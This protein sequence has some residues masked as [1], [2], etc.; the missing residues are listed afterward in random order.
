[1]EYHVTFFNG[2][3]SR[4]NKS[5]LIIRNSNWLIEY[6]DPKGE[7]IHCFWLPAF[8][9]PVEVTGRIVSLSYGSFPPA[10]LECDDR[11]LLNELDHT[12]GKLSVAGKM[13]R[14]I[15]EKGSRAMVG[16]TAGLIGLV[17]LIYFIFLPFIAE[18]IAG[19][20]PV[21]YEQKLGYYIS[22]Q[23]LDGY[24]INEE[25]SEKLNKFSQE[26]NFDLD[27]DPNIVAVESE[28]VNA[29]ALPGG[30]IVVFTGLLKN[31]ENEAQLAALLCHEV[32]H[33]KYRHSLKAM[34]RNLAGY[35][36]ISW[37]FTDIN[38]VTA[39]IV[40]NAH[41]LY[42]LNYSREL[43]HEADTK[44]LEMLEENNISQ[45]GMVDLFIILKKEEAIDMTSINFLSTHPLTVERI[46]YSTA[47]AEKQKSI[48]K[49][50]N[51]EQIWID[52]ENI[53]EE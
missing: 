42:S 7:L 32:A 24:Y 1:M 49:N 8:I 35:L 52:I 28:Q 11:K 51:L 26:I 37:L 38:A 25:L 30:T 2:L 23:F 17:A 15:E 6:T 53:L 21:S 44:A 39:I 50:E 12:K 13:F 36:F 45:Q 33:V 41:S 46:N 5:K 40:E 43:E 9:K 20:M 22:N 48:E 16:L 27:F 4:A 18:I 19:T 14:F 47:S 3:S 10:T 29:F 31:M 34:F